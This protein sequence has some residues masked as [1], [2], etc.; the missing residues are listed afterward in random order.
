MMT[1]LPEAPPTTM[2]TVQGRALARTFL[3]CP[4]IALRSWTFSG[5][6]LANAAGRAGRLSA[7]RMGGSL[8]GPSFFSLMS[9]GA[10]AASA[11]RASR[12]PARGGLQDSETRPTR[13]VGDLAGR[14]NRRRPVVPASVPGGGRGASVRATVRRPAP[15][16]PTVQR[17]APGRGVQSLSAHLFQTPG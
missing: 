6:G 1:P 8:G 2:P 17:I 15:A 7:L 10:G 13:I 12:A 4:W 5:A 11:A 9:A 16:R 3:T 14:M